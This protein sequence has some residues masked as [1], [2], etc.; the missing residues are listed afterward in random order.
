MDIRTI[1]VIGA[2][3]SCMGISHELLASQDCSACTRT[4]NGEIKGTATGSVIAFKGIPYAKAPVG[5]LRFRPPQAADTWEGLLDASHYRATCP[6]VRDPLEQYPFPGRTIRDTDGKQSE[7][8]ENEDCLQLSVWTPAVDHKKRPIMIFIPGGA[9]VVGNGSSNFY[10]G[11]RLAGHDVVVVTLNYRVGLFGFMELGAL[12]NH[13]AGSGNNGLRDQI[14]AIEWV[15]R[16][17]A[18]FGGDPDNVTVFGESAGSISISALLSTQQPSKWFKRAIAQSGASNFIHSKDFALNAGKTIVQ[19]GGYPSVEQLLKATPQQLLETQQKAVVDAGV[20]DLLFAPFIDGTLII[21]EPN[22]LLSDGNAQGIDLMLGATQ[23]E[24]N[25]WSLYDGQY[26]NMF[27]ESTDFGPA[28]T[29]IPPQYRTDLES[30]LGTRLDQR[31]A[32][33]L[34][35]DQH[36]LI[37]QAQNDD[38]AMIQPMR[39]MAERQSARN[40][41]VYLYRFQWKVPAD[42]LPKGVPDLGAVHALDLPFVFG[43]LDLGWVPGGSRLEQAK[44]DVDARL[45]AQMMS[46]WTNFARTGN[47]NGPNVPQWPRYETSHRKTMVWSE[48]SKTESDPESERRKLWENENFD[49]LL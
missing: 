42:Y 36:N 35:L 1:A 15:K 47:P 18:A 6:Q 4:E 28:T 26:R 32:A 29:A 14:A 7:I 43:T 41:N 37:R 9:F 10:D 11:S 39:R 46:A 23:N 31:Y 17:A 12:D 40:A 22:K 44:R 3:L 19:A 30:R 49:S 16:N 13:Y 8:Y 33:L 5:E 38:Y 21:D 48:H 45:S 34:K 2:L 27:V 24:L 25:Y 20:G